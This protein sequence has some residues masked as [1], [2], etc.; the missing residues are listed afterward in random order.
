MKTKSIICN[1]NEILQIY[2]ARLEKINEY[3]IVPKK[4]Y[5]HGGRCDKLIT[6]TKISC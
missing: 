6:I 2:N 3:T 5:F 4:Y 1:G